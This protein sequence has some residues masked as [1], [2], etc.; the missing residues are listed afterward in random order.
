M[1]ELEEMLK[2][3]SDEEPSLRKIDKKLSIFLIYLVQHENKI[4]EMQKEVKN[5]K[6]GV[7]KWALGILSS[8]VVAVVTIVVK[9]KVS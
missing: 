4:C 2:G 7:F 9:G 1:S 6:D 5:T 8:I 3:V